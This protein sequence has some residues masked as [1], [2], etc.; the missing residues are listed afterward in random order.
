M[1]RGESFDVAF[2]LGPKK[3]VTLRVAAR[4]L[5]FF[6]KSDKKLQ[7]LYLF[8]EIY[9]IL[10]PERFRASPSG[11]KQFPCIFFREIYQALSPE[12]L[13]ASPSGEKA[14]PNVVFRSPGSDFGDKTFPKYHPKSIKIDNKPVLV[15][16]LD[17]IHFFD[18][19][20][21]PT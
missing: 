10:P 13:R 16:S 12:R 21:I 9:H 11:K 8:T 5:F 6:C 1:K 2:T 19:K 4:G 3:I 18:P 7:E 17:K 15:A 20:W 14:F